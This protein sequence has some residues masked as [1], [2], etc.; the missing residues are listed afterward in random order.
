METYPTYHRATAGNNLSIMKKDWTELCMAKGTHE[1]LK[2]A[3]AILC[4]CYLH[5]GGQHSL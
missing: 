4:Y 1:V 3:T 2:A 5:F